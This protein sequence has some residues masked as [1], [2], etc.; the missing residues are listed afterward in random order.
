MWP[1]QPSSKWWRLW[2]V[3]WSFGAA[4]ESLSQAQGL[5]HGGTCSSL[6]EA[7]L[8]LCS[9]SKLAKGGVG[10]IAKPNDPS[11]TW[12]EMR[13]SGFFTSRRKMSVSKR[14][15][16][17]HNGNFIWVSFTVSGRRVH[18]CD[19]ATRLCTDSLSSVYKGSVHPKYKKTCVSSNSGTSRLQLAILLSVTL[20]NWLVIWS[21][22][23]RNLAA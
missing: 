5:G 21:K 12:V 11:F 23:C 9:K 13:I 20:I 1:S 4:R 18:L 17:T 16:R 19:D 3:L 14:W 15:G 6:A 22:K 7:L 10:R 2:G 8:L